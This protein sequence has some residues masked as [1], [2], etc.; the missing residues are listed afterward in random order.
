MYIYD[1]QIECIQDD[2]QVR[3]AEGS[4]VA[5]DTILYCTGYVL[6][7]AVAHKMVLYLFPCVST[8]TTPELNLQSPLGTA[9]IFRSWTWMGSPS[10]TTAS[11]HCTSTSSHPSMHPISL[12]LGC[13]TR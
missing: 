3:F 4:S 7:I 2:G 9:T 5:A 10:T 1:K 8:F 11:G 13:H 12:S 6:T